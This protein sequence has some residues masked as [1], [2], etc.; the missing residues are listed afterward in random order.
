MSFF[1]GDGFDLYAQPTDAAAGYWDS[2]SNFNNCNLQPGRFSGSRALN[3]SGAPFGIKTS[4]VLTDAIHHFNVAYWQAGNTTSANI[5]FYVT[6]LDGTTSQCSIAIRGDGGIILTS[7]AWNSG[8]T[9]ASWFGPALVGGVWYSFEFEVQVSSTNGYMAVRK[10]GN[11]N[12]DFRSA[13]NL[14]TR[15]SGNNYANKINVGYAQSI[16]VGIYIDDFLWRSEASSVPWIGDIRCYTRHPVSPD[17]VAQFSRTSAAINAVMWTGVNVQQSYS[18]NNAAYMQFTATYSG[19]LTGLIVG[20]NS[21]GSTGHFKAAVFSSVNDTV[22]SVLAVTS[23]L[24]NPT[25]LVLT[26]P[27]P[28]YLTAGQSYWIGQINDSGTINMNVVNSP[29]GITGLRALAASY[30]SW[31]VSSPNAPVVSG[32]VSGLTLVFTPQSNADSVSELYQDGTTN[33]VYSSTNGANDLYN[34][35]PIGALPLQ[36]FGVVTRGYFE[37][38]DSGTRNATVQLKSGGT[39]VQGPDT[40]LTTATWGWIARTDLTDP[41]SGAAW[42]VGAVNGV[43]IGPRVTQ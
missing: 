6:L 20:P 5:G 36:I 1:F 40:A 27:S 30:A 14:N 17:V 9:L 38:S 23:E 13:T 33:Y 10:N 11:P 32:N 18:A 29:A 22:G 37:K 19:L 2:N 16:G 7:G 25:S 24:T 12:D 21:N 15:Q 31:P 4:S 43:L 26:F 28:A 3:T 42:T 35:G 39:T 41:A 34:I 8:N